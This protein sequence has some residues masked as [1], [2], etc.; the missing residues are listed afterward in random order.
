MIDYERTVRRI[1]LERKGKPCAYEMCFMRKKR[2][3]EGEDEE[4]VYRW[5]FLMIFDGWMILTIM[6]SMRS[7]NK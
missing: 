7:Q 3:E 2:K 4:N 6:I 1:T 5:T